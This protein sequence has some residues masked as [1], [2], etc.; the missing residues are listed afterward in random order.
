MTCAP[1]QSCSGR[2]VAEVEKKSEED[3]DRERSTRDDRELSVAFYERKD[4]VVACI[5]YG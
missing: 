3:V 5:V 4:D 1:C 2:V